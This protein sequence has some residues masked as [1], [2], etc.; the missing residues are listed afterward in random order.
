MRIALEEARIAADE[1]EIPVGAV[2]VRENEVLARAH[3]RCEE[4]HF[5]TAHA[6]LLAIEAHPK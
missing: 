2:I 3:N 5:A 6:E 1:G 4:S